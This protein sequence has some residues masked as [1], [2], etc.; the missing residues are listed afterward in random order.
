ME[1]EINTFG[2]ILQYGMYLEQESARF[3]AQA[4]Q[5]AQNAGL[6]QALAELAEEAQRRHKTLERIR[7]ENV[8]EMIL[9][10]IHDFRSR[11]YQ[12]EFQVA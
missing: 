3:Y 7:R 10:P 9:T 12:P 1:L 2:A 4:A 11:D 6:R 8:T 5:A